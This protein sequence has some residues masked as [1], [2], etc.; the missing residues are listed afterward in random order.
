MMS[1]HVMVAYNVAGD[2]GLEV[3]LDDCEGAVK[4]LWDRVEDPV[5]IRE[6]FERNPPTGWGPEE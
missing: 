2:L 6:Y 3:S 4:E 5:A 1:D